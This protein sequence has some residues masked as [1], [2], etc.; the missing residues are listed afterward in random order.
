MKYPIQRVMVTGG[1][2]FIGSH[3]VDVLLDSGLEPIV[4]DNLAAYGWGAVATF[5]LACLII[6]ST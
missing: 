5:R 4:V 2:G 1:A 6:K 3:T